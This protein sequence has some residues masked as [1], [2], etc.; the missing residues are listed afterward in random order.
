MLTRDARGEPMIVGDAAASPERFEAALGDVVRF[1]GDP[2]GKIEAALAADPLL[3]LWHLLRAHTFL[4]A[5]QPGF[6]AKAAASIAAAEALAGQANERERLH[7]AAAKAWGG[8]DL[9]SASAVFDAV[10]AAHPR[11]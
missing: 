2:I 5:L 1:A 10:L 3:V 6:G 7:L 4:F 9:T 8:G 11:G